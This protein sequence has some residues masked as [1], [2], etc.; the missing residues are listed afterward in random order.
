MS[1]KFLSFIFLAAFIFSF[2]CSRIEEKKESVNE[3]I[4]IAYV[5]KCIAL[6]DKNISNLSSDV[7]K[8]DGMSSS[9]VR[10]LLNNL[11]GMPN[12]NY[13]EIGVWKGSTWVSAL[14]QNQNNL[15]SAVAIDNWCQ[16][17]TASFF[18]ENSNRYLKELKDKYQVITADSFNLKKEG[19][20]KNPVNVYFYDGEHTKADQKAAFT[21]YNDILDDVFVA[22]VD[23]WNFE[24]VPE[25]TKEA[26]K[27]LNYKVL[28]ETILPANHNGDRANWWN[29]LY[30]AVIRK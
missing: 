28:F 8:L 13:L 2:S 11:G 26:F 16:T 17:G 15:I 29:G 6:A 12:L 4:L 23:D 20:F 19:I 30:V 3:K 25:G 5:Q 10:H 21:Y 24:G 18:L 27:E 22:I 1:H 7:L 14:F 9:K